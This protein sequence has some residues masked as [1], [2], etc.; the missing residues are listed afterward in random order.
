MLE[1][2]KNL[3]IR[4]TTYLVHYFCPALD[5]KLYNRILHQHCYQTCADNRQH[6]RKRK[7]TVR[8]AHDQCKKFNKELNMQNKRYYEKFNNFYG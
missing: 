4:N 5:A 6:L 7:S 2:H 8:L 1:K 3:M